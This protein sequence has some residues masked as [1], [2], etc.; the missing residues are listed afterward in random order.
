MIKLI[1]TDLDGTL[2]YPKKK[3]KLLIKKNIKFLK[4]YIESGNR[5]ILV[6]GRNFHIVER[7]KRKLKNNVDM[8]ACNGSALYKDG[9]VIEDS[10]MSHDDVKRLY[11]DNLEN[12]NIISWIYMTDKHN[13][14]FFLG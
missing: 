7:I 4:N 11:E 10:P 9:E 13:M 8:L 12:K 14:I 6:S 5:V 2:F 3:I 1:A